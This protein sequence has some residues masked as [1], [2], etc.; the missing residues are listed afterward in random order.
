MKYT[1]LLFF[2]ILNQIL[3]SQT[4]VEDISLI[5]LKK[6]SKSFVQKFI[7]VQKGDT[8]KIDKIENEVNFLKQLPAFSNVTYSIETKNK[9]A[10]VRYSF[11]EA[12]TLLPEINF[13]SVKNKF[14]YHLGFNEY[15]LLGRNIHLNLA[16]Q[17]NG[18]SSYFANTKIPYLWGDF[19]V[20]L[21][22]VFWKSDEPFYLNGTSFMYEYKNTSYEVM[23]LYYPNFN[24]HF[25][26]GLNYFN[27][28]Y[29]ALTDVSANLPQKV[30]KAKLSTKFNYTF[31]KAKWDFFYIDGIVNNFYSQMVKTEGVTKPYLIFVNDFMYFKR[32][33]SKINV[34]T[35]FRFGLG[36]NEDTPF[37]P[38]VLDNH[39]V[40]RGVGD[41]ID[42]GSGVLVLNTE[43]RYT[44]VENSWGA[45][46]TVV[47]SDLGSW[48]LPGG[49]FN[50][51]FDK[52]IIR[53]HLGGGV[54]FIYKKAFNTILRI[55]YGFGIG[56]NKEKGIVLGFGQYF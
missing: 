45:I 33:N 38:F 2:I 12:F 48:R 7:H 39:V 52:K 5:G 13:W 55:D 40:I 46:Q 49:S 3:L 42:R 32:I 16:Y 11:Q 22:F 54:R 15:N 17:N 23:T 31:N 24:N 30:Q 50:D 6:T 19:G 51:F 26:F 34:A 56:F 47:F 14:T 28:G 9:K 4:K 27:E 44:A 29:L 20:Y 36:T 18:K 43:L 37:S 10:F 53:W 25:E 21:G 35:R 41:R 8:L 1:Y